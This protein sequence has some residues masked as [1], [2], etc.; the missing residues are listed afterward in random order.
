VGRTPDGAIVERAPPSIQPSSHLKLQL[1]QADFT[2]ATRVVEAINKHFAQP[3]SPIARAESSGLL[4]VDV[5]P[6]YSTR[7]VEF[8]SEME[9]LTVD[10]DRMARIVINE[11]TGTIVMGKEVRITPVAIMH[12]A[13]SVEIRTKVEV[14]QPPPGSKGTTAVVN[15][16]SVAVQDPKARSLVLEKGA[17]VEELVRALQA[18][19]STPRDVLAILQ[20]MKAAGA[21]DAEIEVI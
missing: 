6:S 7:T 19:G 9:S 16:T 21:L 20:A 2:T 8:I 18:I 14:S 12:G 15:Q 3:G 17:T 4:V 5:P 13:L 1:R 11:R 10:A